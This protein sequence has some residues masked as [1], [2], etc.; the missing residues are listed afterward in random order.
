MN[1]NA[2]FMELLVRARA[3]PPEVLEHAGDAFD[4]GELSTESRPVFA[5]PPAPDAAKAW[6]SFLRRWK[7]AR[8]RLAGRTLLCGRV[9]APG[10]EF[11]II[12]KASPPAVVVCE[13]T[14]EGG[15]VPV[16]VRLCPGIHLEVRSHGSYRGVVLVAEE[17]AVEET[18]ARARA[19]AAFG[20]LTRWFD[21]RSAHA[22]GRGYLLIRAGRL[23]RFIREVRMLLESYA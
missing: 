10:C 19:S 20:E 13:R 1:L 2:T 4:V 22:G 11:W 9:P 16:R 14:E 12:L 15:S 7:L 21:A 6:E 18:L 5:R 17:P 8:A 23:P 3:V